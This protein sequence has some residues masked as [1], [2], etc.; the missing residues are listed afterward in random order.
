MLSSVRLKTIDGFR[1]IAVLLVV[2]SHAVTYRFESES[3]LFSNY[4]RR[5][6]GPLAEIGV[7]IFFV[8]SGFIITS[9]LLR[10]ELANTKI[11]IPAFYVR[12]T[13]RILPP[14]LFY[15]GCCCSGFSAGLSFQ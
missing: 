9:L 4:V 14:L 6:A 12:R 13:F 7:Q 15:M 8:I 2:F 1:G 11:N 5:L 3:Y 10:E